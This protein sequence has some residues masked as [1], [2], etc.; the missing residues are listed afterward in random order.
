MARGEPLG[1]ISP[2]SSAGAI[3]FRLERAATCAISCTQARLFWSG[4]TP[5]PLRSPSTFG[6][7]SLQFFLRPSSGGDCR[8]A[9]GLMDHACNLPPGNRVRTHGESTVATR[10][11]AQAPDEQWAKD[12][13]FRRVAYASLALAALA[14][15]I[16]PDLL[17]L[18]AQQ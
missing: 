2:M 9:S 13:R 11:S 14:W 7:F 1:G 6:K 16:C 3:V 5:R 17:G 4:I 10:N 15:R 18:R 8:A 12:E